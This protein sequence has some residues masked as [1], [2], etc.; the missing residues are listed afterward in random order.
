MEV[1]FENPVRKFHLRELSRFTR[2]SMPTIISAT[3]TLH[4]EKMILKHKSKAVTTVEANRENIQFIR[5]KRA[6]NLE[7]TYVSTIVDYLTSAYN[8]PKAIIVFGSYSRG[9]DTEQSDVDIA[10]VTSKKA[11][12]S[13][14]PY[15]KIMKRKI[16]IHEIELDKVSAE[17]KNNLTN[18]IVLAGT[19]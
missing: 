9:E 14:A 19:L 8:H 16:S 2:L 4:K 13:L 5:L 17:F 10:V 15:E 3:N 1:F 11:K 6:F 12:L 18:G 7:K